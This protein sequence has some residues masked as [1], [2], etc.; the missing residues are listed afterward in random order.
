MILQGTFGVTAMVVSFVENV[1]TNELEDLL[2]AVPW[3][4]AGWGLLV[5][6][7]IAQSVLLFR[8]PESN[9]STPYRVGVFAAYVLGLLAILTFQG[10]P[11]T[12]SKDS[13]VLCVLAM[14]A[15]GLS[16]LPLMLED[17]VIGRKAFVELPK[18]RLH[19]ILMFPLL[20]SAGSGMVFL[21]L[22]LVGIVLLAPW[23]S[24]SE[25]EFIAL[26]YT[27]LQTFA[28]VAMLLPRLRKLEIVSQLSKR[29]VIVA[30]YMPVM[31]APFGILAFL[32]RDP[33]P[34]KWMVTFV[35]P[36]AAMVDEFRRGSIAGMEQ[37]AALCA[38]VCVIVNFS[39]LRAAWN[40]VV[41]RQHPAI[42]MA[43]EPVVEASDEA[44]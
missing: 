33:T 2:V 26:I 37:W 5:Y 41:L 4:V 35:F 23:S 43:N 36:L 11:G 39:A 8:H 40:I 44:V 12:I 25:T 9:R 30:A 18:K 1:S 28:F 27:P 15:C 17:E 38:L 14:G 31:A 24:V 22:M 10:L 13:F 6:F 21:I 3:M 16:C 29:N 19:R 20:P 7:G 42:Q 34:L 32:I